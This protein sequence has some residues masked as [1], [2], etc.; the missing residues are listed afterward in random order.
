MIKLVVIFVLILAA[1]FFGY[2]VGEIE[3][4]IIYDLP[5]VVLQTSLLGTLIILIVSILVLILVSYFVLKL[6]RVANGSRNWLGFRAKRMQTDAFYQCI[7]AMLI[8]DQQSALK[9]IRKTASGDFQGSQLLIAAE[10]EKQAGQTQQA[11]AFL[12]QAQDNPKTK[13]LSLFKQAELSLQNGK[14]QDAMTHLSCVEGKLRKNKAF[15]NLKLKVLEGLN[16]WPQIYSFARENKKLIGDDYYT[17]A[18]QWTSGEFASI[19]SKEGINA[20]KSHWQQMSR[21]QRKDQANQ[22]AYLQ[23]LIDHGLSADA[24]VEL[25][26]IASKQSNRSYWLLFKQLNHPSPSKAM[27]FIE[28]AIKKSPEDAELYSVLANLAY[29]S[30][31]MELAH[32]AVAKALELDNKPA[33]RALLAS[34]L[35]KNQDFKEANALYKELL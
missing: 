26:N 11:Q 25:V 16:D 9:L 24:E 18:Q 15:V 6:I 3:G 4:R 5:G 35:E 28:Q 21:A 31:D 1:L 23:L 29:N 34:I 10:L 13:D 14:A 33:D 19:A 7:N 12:I 17:W 8:N 22:L 20:L 27:Q 2:K 32:K 30:N